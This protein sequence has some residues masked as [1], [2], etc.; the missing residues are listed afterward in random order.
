M[1]K[2]ALIANNGEVNHVISTHVDTMYLD[3][4]T[5]NGLLARHLPIDANNDEYISR[6]YWDFVSNVWADRAPRPTVAM[7]WQDNT[8]VLDVEALFSEIRQHRDMNLALSDWTQ[9]PDS[10]LSDNKKV[11]WAAYR[12]VLR[13]IP[14]TYSEAIFLDD[15]IWPIKPE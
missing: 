3:G 2:V 8:W 11:E 1:N 12:Q 7:I 15:I 4:S 9:F 6:K 5:Y 10:P 14:Y 13:D